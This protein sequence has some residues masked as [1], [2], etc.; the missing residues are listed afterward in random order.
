MTGR[1][2]AFA[3]VASLAAFG[4][5]AIVDSVDDLPTTTFDF[6]VVGGGTAGN[7]IANRLTENPE[8]SVLVLEAG[9]SNE[10]ILNSMVPAFCGLNQA[11]QIDWNY[12]AQVGPPN[13]QPVPYPRGFVL[14]GSSSIN[15]LAYTRGSSED[16]DRYARV[17]GDDGWA[18]DNI[19]P[20][21]RKNERFTPPV[22]G[23]NITGQFD[24]MVHG[25]DGINSVSLS[26]FL[27]QMDARVIQASKSF[28]A[29]NEFHFNLDTN[30]GDQLG[31][32]FGQATTFNGTRSS[33]ATSYLAPQFVGRPNL[34]VLL[35]AHVTRIL[36]A[37]PN[38]DSLSFS[39]VEFSQDS[40][41]TL[42][43]VTASKEIVLSAGTIGTPQ[44]LLL[45]GIGDPD[46]LAPLGIT[47]LHDLPSVGR[48]L[49]EQPVAFYPWQVT[50]NDTSDTA[51]R[52]ATLAAQQLQM[53]ETQRRGPLVNG[54]LLDVGWVRVPASERQGFDDPSAG[55]NTAHLEL[56][57]LNGAG[58]TA[59]S[60]NF[61]SASPVLVSPASREYT[62]KDLKSLTDR[63]PPLGGSVTLNSA[64]PFDHPTLSLNLVSDPFDLLALRSGLRAVDRFMESPTFDGFVVSAALNVTGGLASNATDDELD[65][66]IKSTTI[67]ALHIVGTASMSAQNASWGVVNSDLKVKGV[68]GLR[69]ADASILPFSPAAHTQAPVYIVA[70]RAADLIKASWT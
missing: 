20:Y 54:P 44:I 25:F 18:W 35:H 59:P 46:V 55:P 37:D 38:S 5:G 40:G 15:C 17:S 27:T 14:G 26:G 13:R 49:T 56:Q 29:D 31:I 61:I 48:N 6:I 53:W 9:G 68:Q 7:V 51:G 42:H 58:A 3:L 16:W 8:F 57:F 21:I 22:D 70:E 62:Y 30:S 4:L 28:P 39:N 36:P 43:T 69:V 60:G 52:N 63:Q 10:G 45:S 34:H 11:T 32:G 65:N 23:H 33:S 67:G 2:L 1:N 47:P 24:P 19:Q 66:Y 64:N 50:A 41:G 12:T